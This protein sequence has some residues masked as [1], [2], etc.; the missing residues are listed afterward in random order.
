M[1]EITL[2][3]VC[4]S[5]HKEHYAVKDFNLDIHDGEFV[6]FVGPSGCG[7]STT[8]RM[9]A[10][11]EEITG[12]ELWIDKQLCNYIEPK[13]RDLSMVFQNYALYPQMTVYDNMAFALQIRKVP[14]QEI[15]QKVHEAAAIL[16]IEQL[17]KRRPGQLSGGQK[18]RVAI[19]SAI[20]R[21]PKAF[22]MDEPLSNLDAKL[23]AQMRVEL[24]DLHKRLGTTTIYVTHDQ[25]EA[26][27]MSD[28]IVVMKDGEIQQVGT[29][30]DI[31]NEPANRFVANF[32]GES[33]IIP[34]VMLTD[35]KV[36]FDDITFDCVD[37]GFK[38][39]EPVD[40]VIRPEDID[41]VDVSAGKMTGEVLSVL[42]KG[43]HYEIMVE[44]VPG[45]SVT[46]N[47]RVIR[48]HDIKSE[49]GKE[50]I[51]A[52]DFYVDID[53]V[54]ELD[55]KEI[56]ALSNAQAWDPDADEFISIA[57]V[58]YEL[59]KEEGRYPV[60]FSTS[61]GTSIEKSIYV[62]DQP[63]VKNEKANEGVMA[64]NFFKTVDE[65]TES[66][67]LDTDLKTWAGAQAWKLSNE[68]EAVDLSVD[69]DFEP[70]NV[71]E[72]VY[73]ITFSTTGRE[74][75]IHTTDYTEEGQE[76]GLTFFPEDIHVMSREVF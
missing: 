26:L 57:K 9:I 36:R 31:Y 11:L 42:F 39:K 14:K 51:S 33:N 74:F 24:A 35:Y 40:V 48:N 13:D 23:R 19:G 34:G 25:E 58:E 55:D 21:R 60:T 50:M 7:K 2:R 67:A 12:G 27:T 69:Y 76:V 68:D 45:T 44:T 4:K 41:I 70:E 10:G 59:S 15:N 65:I 16:G 43:V 49:D 22:L 30:Q 53:D 1:S 3:N 56:I 6:I 72:G 52:N 28:K 64:F 63:F 73:Q 18:Q 29:P 62:V 37:F 5:Y 38:E 46:V 66:Q 47:M 54:E 61:N 8:L 71:K 17:L 75:K 32:I 20:M